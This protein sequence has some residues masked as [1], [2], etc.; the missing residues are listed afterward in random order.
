MLRSGRTERGS[1]RM[2]R[3]GIGTVIG[4]KTSS[5]GRTYTRAWIYVPTEVFRDTSFPLAVGDPCWVE[6]DN[7][8]KRLIVSPIP[9]D[10]AEREGWVKRQRATGHSP[11]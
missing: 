6:I 7:E 1:F 8:Q 5:G 11:E 9:E 10:E 4:R 2:A 3:K